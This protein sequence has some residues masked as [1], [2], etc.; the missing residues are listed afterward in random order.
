MKKAKQQ[1]LTNED[2][3]RDMVLWRDSH[4]TI[5]E[6][7]ISDT[8]ADDMLK[9]IQH[10]LRHHRF[11]NYP[12]WMKDEMRQEA[13]LKIMKNLKNIK[14]DE[15]YRGKLFSYWTTCAWTAFIVYLKQHYKYNNTKKK[16]TLQAI[17]QV[18]EDLGGTEYAQQVREGL[19]EYLKELEGVEEK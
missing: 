16:L 4:S 1:F 19:N 11:S 12:Q 18:M 2:I 10:L 15:D 13:F 6:R 5:S 7:T 8:M 14:L 17:D 9:L 3:Y